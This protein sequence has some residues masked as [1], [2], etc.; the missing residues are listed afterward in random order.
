[1]T[2]TALAP[3][4][5][6]SLPSIRS[7]ATLREQIGPFLG[8]LAAI[9]GRRPNTILSYGR[10]LRAFV[11]FAAAAGIVRPADI[12]F[13]HLEAYFGYRQHHEGKKATTINRARYALATFFQFLRR[14]GLV[15]QNPVQD[16]FALPRPTR[17]PKYLSIAT[18]ERVLAGLAARPS[19]AGRRD[20][21]MIAVAL[22]CGLRVSELA[23]ARVSDL[24]LEAGLLTIVGKGDKQRECVVVPRLRVILE[25]YLARTRPALAGQRYGS[26]YLFTRSTRRSVA[27]KS[28][29]PILT[30]SIHWILKHHVSRLAEQ[31]VFPHMLRHSFASRLRENGAPLELIQ[32][33][34]GHANIATTLIYAHLSTSRQRADI[35]KY[36]KGGA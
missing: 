27:G 6:P 1:M 24:N 36:L 9:R 16:T 8:W 10:D 28:P 14:Q 13:N 33:A 32:E 20:Y 23:S 2:T 11:G 5:A 25:D 30:R 34:L 35:A 18:Q 12:S 29:G 26:P 4:V 19:L 21:A 7:G 31:P 17:I 22:F 3:L 15:T